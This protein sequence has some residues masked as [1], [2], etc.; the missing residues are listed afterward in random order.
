MTANHQAILAELYE[1][2]PSL[3]EHE[4]EL[5]PLLQKLLA[6]DPAQRPSP[7]F[8]KKLRSELSARMNAM[9]GRLPAGRQAVEH[10][11][12]YASPSG[13]FNRFAYALAGAVA[14]VV[15]A[16]PVT[17]Q[18]AENG[19]FA[20]TTTDERDSQA[21]DGY[22]AL[23]DSDSTAPSMMGATP[24]AN[25]PVPYAMGRTQSGGGGG[26]MMMDGKMSAVSPLIAPWNPVKYRLEGDLPAL[27]QGEVE[28]LER[29]LRPLNI[30]FAS[31]QNAFKDAA[32]DVSSFEGTSV[33]N[34]SV[35]QR[36]QFGYT[37]NLSM[38]DGSVNINQAWEYWPHPE[39]DCRDDACYERFRTKL[40]DIP[41]DAEVIRIA[42]A[43]IDDHDI[44]L[45]SYGEPFVDNAWRSEFE[46]VEDKRMAWVP[47]SVRVVYPLVVDG[48][49]VT[50]AGGGAAGV[51]VQV[52]AKHKRVSDVWGLTTYQFDRTDHPAVTERADVEKFLSLSGGQNPEAPTVTLKN[53]TIGFVRLYTYEDGAN[54]E[55]FVPALIFQVTDVPKDV[56]YYQTSV[57][58]PLSK[59]LLD[60]AELSLPFDD[61]Q[62]KPIEPYPM[63][64]PRPMDGGPAIDVPAEEPFDDAQGKPLMMEK[65]AR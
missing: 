9:A 46:R 29:N 28:V 16:V 48:K 23:E 47:D 14:A 15:I 6:N 19:G 64:M 60:E 45:S 41:A 11:V 39:S 7:A 2:D 21:A 65:E 25:N 10:R 31:I 12:T 5:V 20:P 30:P 42:N 22:V 43:F 37:I 49:T 58:V 4:A 61:T 35:T 18:W 3:R 36:T 40:S 34:V 50:E 51:S 54:K 59:E 62:G 55:L 38:Q 8:V 33:D 27:P 52:S 17:M 44:D 32:I 53:P 57:A 24:T 63:P 13:F 26:D 1:I 56:F